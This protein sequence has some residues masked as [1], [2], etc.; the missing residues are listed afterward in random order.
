MSLDL[1]PGQ[2]WSVE[3]ASRLD[4]TDTGILCVTTENQN[5]SWLNFEAGVL[6]RSVQHA[7]VIPYVLGTLPGIPGPIGQ[8]QAVRATA[9]DTRRLVK[10]LL[11]SAPEAGAFD[12][13]MFEAFWP[14]LDRVITAAL[15]GESTTEAALSEIEILLEARQSL[16]LKEIRVSSE[17]V[18]R[19]DALQIQYVV[20]TTAQGLSCW[21]GASMWSGLEM[22]IF[23][24]DEDA[25]IRLRRG[26]Q[27]YS[28]SL[29][30]PFDA[31]PGEYKLNAEVWYG[32]RSDSE[33]S[34][35]LK[36][37]WPTRHTLTVQP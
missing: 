7:Q 11:A 26:L 15:G 28:R 16:K 4:A 27:Q 21:L 23:N 37:Q 9:D 17:R 36:G 30:I 24:R 18:T 5:S 20:E 35:P 2:R 14:P 22:P 31:P 25:L 32:P 29:T 33:T 8:F 34:Y 10:T 19:G 13:R 12:P 3:L 1:T 6:S